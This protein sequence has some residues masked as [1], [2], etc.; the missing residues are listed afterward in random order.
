[1]AIAPFSRRQWASHSLRVTGKELSIVGTRGKNNAIA[2]RFSKYQLAAE[3]GNSE[4]KKAAADPL[5]PTLCSGN[6]SVLK[7]WWEQP[8]QSSATSCAPLPH[9]RCLLPLNP[10]AKHR[11]QPQ[12]TQAQPPLSPDPNTSPTAAEDQAGPGMERRLQQRDPERQEAIAEVPCVPSEKPNIPLNNLK[13]LFEKGENQQNK[14]SKAPVRIGGITDNMDQLLGDAGSMDSM[15][16]R[17]RM[18]M[19][20]AAVSKSEVSSSVSGDQLD[21][22]LLCSSKQKENVPPGSGDMGSDSEPNSRKASSTE[23][24][25]GSSIGTSVSSTQND[26][27]QPKNSRS[28]CLPAQESCVSCQKTVYPLERLV[29]NQQVYH[30]TCFRCSHCNT[31]LSLGTYASLHSH[32]YCKPHFCQLFKAKG[33]YD[34]GF[35]LRPH[36]ELWETKGEEQGTEQTTEVPFSK[37]KLKKCASTGTLL[38]SPAVEESPLAK[39]NVV[40]ASLETRT[41]ISVEKDKPVETRR[42]KISWPPRTEGDGEGGNM[43]SSPTSDGSSGGRPSRAKWPPEGDSA[44]PDQSPESTERSTLCRSSS[45][46]ERSQ[47]FSLASPSHVP[48]PAASQTANPEPE[49]LERMSSLEDREPEP[50]SS[51]EEQSIEV[52]EQP[53]S[54]SPDYHT[55]SDNSYVDVQTSSEEEGREAPLKESH[56]ESLESK[57][58][59]GAK[60]DWEE[61]EEE[62]MEGEE[63]GEGLPSQNCQTA[64]SEIV[65]P[66][67]SP[68]AEPRP[69]TNHMSQDVGFWDGKEAVSVEEMIKRNRYYEKDEDEE[70]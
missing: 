33:N 36:K 27:A 54:L 43:G 6:L 23:S 44:F 12:A 4:R 26:Q 67:S 57:E 1:M 10:K 61:D 19:Y 28:F 66:P 49:L 31:K 41:Q 45:L 39:V 14:V 24:N 11:I 32:V 3:E 50:A 2:E 42:L 35:G 48:A 47:P 65:T 60:E 16:L 46:K 30:N 55:P 18:A 21:S 15:P 69:K 53:D 68:E 52:Q 22:D 34:E 59:Q 40:T 8:V 9:T 62:K 70:D 51:P 58:E 7:K 63:D 17:D 25:A 64:S 29:A 13:M 37:D 5:P 56:H 20:Q 38:I